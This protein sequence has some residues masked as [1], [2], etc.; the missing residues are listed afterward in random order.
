MSLKEIIFNLM[1][2]LIS[3]SIIPIF[4]YEFQERDP[5]LSF[6]PKMTFTI[7]SLG[8][9]I[10]YFYDYNKDEDDYY[11]I[12]QYGDNVFYNNKY[13]NNNINNK[14]YCQRT[15]VDN[16]ERISEFYTKKSL[17]ELFETNKFKQML[18][19]KGKDK[20]NW[21]WQSRDRLAGKKQLDESEINSYIIENMTISQD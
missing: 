6:M 18:E 7:I 20:K 10:W 15:D 1:I 9:I 2:F 16:Y 14:P 17:K 12:N 8:I 21:N 5:T 4:I 13:K 11:Y 3:I 19:E